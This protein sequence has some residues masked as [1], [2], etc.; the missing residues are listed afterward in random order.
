MIADGPYACSS[1]MASSPR[2][3][4]QA[5]TG[6]KAVTFDLGRMAISS[7]APVTGAVTNDAPLWLSL[8]GT[9]RSAPTVMVGSIR[10]P[11]M[12][13]RRVLTVKLADGTSALHV[14]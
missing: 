2:T 11:A 10:V 3:M 5:P 9:W 1:D 7:G 12:L 13:V 8:K 14:G 4:P 6:A